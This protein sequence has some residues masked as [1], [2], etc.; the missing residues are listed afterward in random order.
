MAFVYYSVQLQKVAL[1]KLESQMTTLTTQ[2]AM[3]SEQHA[4]LKDEIASLRR[5]GQ[6]CDKLMTE[7]GDVHRQYINV[8]IEDLRAEL[9]KLVS[10]TATRIESNN[11]EIQEMALVQKILDER[12]ETQQRAINEL[13]KRDETDNKQAQ[14]VQ[15]VHDLLK[16]AL[17]VLEA[18]TKIEC[19]TESTRKYHK[20]QDEVN[21]L[22]QELVKATSGLKLSINYPESVLTRDVKGMVIHISMPLYCILP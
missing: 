4:A 14:L 18:R 17:S 15:S 1:S 2:F 20:L 3:G 6:E 11:S 13:A 16:K 12:F 22:R 19:S 8:E 7:Q 10:D 21:R 9:G 5:S